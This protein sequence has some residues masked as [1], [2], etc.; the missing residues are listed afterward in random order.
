[1]ITD[2]FLEDISARVDFSGSL[3]VDADI[4]TVVSVIAS[5]PRT[6]G[7]L[8]LPEYDDSQSVGEVPINIMLQASISYSFSLQALLNFVSALPSE[9]PCQELGIPAVAMSAFQL[10]SVKALLSTLTQL[11]APK[12]LCTDDKESVP[13]EVSDCLVELDSMP[14][15]AP[16]GTTLSHECVFSGIR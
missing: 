12:P 14:E 16:L 13:V 5:S 10:S 7:L 8:S 6:S 3:S 2:R 11:C 4:D 15:T 1:M 9:I